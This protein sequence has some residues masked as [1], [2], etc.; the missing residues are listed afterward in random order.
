MSELREKE[1]KKRVVQEQNDVLLEI[2]KD[3][4][5]GVKNFKE[6]AKGKE[7]ESKEKRD[8]VLSQL[9]DKQGSR[10]RYFQLLADTLLNRLYIV[11]G[12]RPGWHYNT[13]VTN[14]GIVMELSSP[15]GRLFRSAF[16][17][18][19]DPLLDLN[20]L[21]N[22]TYRADSTIEKYEQTKVVA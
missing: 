12:I 6:W 17:V 20:A 14:I 3:G 4:E 19:A 16:S 7:D 18:T 10:M 9:G 5:E 2:G 15:D 21:D 22:F 11:C 1:K 8:I 13:G